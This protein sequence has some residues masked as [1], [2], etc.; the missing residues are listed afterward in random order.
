MFEYKREEVRGELRK[1]QKGEFSGVY[2]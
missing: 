2:C 1:E